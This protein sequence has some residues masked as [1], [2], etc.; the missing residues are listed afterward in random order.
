MTWHAALLDALQVSA[1]RHSLHGMVRS[2]S[3]RGAR[4]GLL[5][6][7]LRVYAVPLAPDSPLGGAL[8]A[9]I[10]SCSPPA[11]GGPG[12]T[13]STAGAVWD[14]VGR[15]RASALLLDFSAAAAASGTA[16]IAKRRCRCLGALL[17]AAH[18][19]RV[20]AFW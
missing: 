17:G 8:A 2:T 14:V 4:R 15:P 11:G 10:G 16:A 13:G 18:L 20:P 6:I 19:R 12:P 3:A 5:G 9:A 1:A 7:Q